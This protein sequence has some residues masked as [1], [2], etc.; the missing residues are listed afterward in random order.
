MYAA[1]QGI[2]DEELGMQAVTQRANAQTG[3]SKAE[4]ICA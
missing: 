3:L 4:R 1:K 2:I